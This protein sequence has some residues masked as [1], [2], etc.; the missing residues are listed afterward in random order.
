MA[1]ILLIDDDPQI[2]RLIS[3]ILRG[4]GHTVREATDGRSGLE[5]FS[6]AAPALVITDLVMPDKEGIETIKEIRTKNLS[7]PILAISGGDTSI[8]LRA[9]IGLG[10]TASLEK[11]F[12]ADELLA[13][14]TELLNAGKP[15]C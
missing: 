14:V 12:A 7:I 1:D 10:A 3:R 2:R 9:A 15:L 6:Q 11:P 4:A 5:L 13:V 8:F